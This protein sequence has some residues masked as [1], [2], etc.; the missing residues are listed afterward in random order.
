MR[1]LYCIKYSNNLKPYYGYIKP[2]NAVRDNTTYSLTYLPPS[3]I[4]GVQK[5][6]GIEGNIVRHRLLFDTNGQQKDFNKAIT[7]EKENKNGSTVH[8][9]YCLVNPQIL[10]GFD[11]KEDAEYCLNQPIHLGQMQYLIY[12]DKKY[13]IVEMNDEEFNNLK[14]VETFLTNENDGLYVG[15]NRQ[16][17]NERMYIDIIRNNW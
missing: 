1:K 17:N 6:L 2:W 7:Y 3:F 16:K 11:N 9:R 14:G 4:D 8:D 10:F 12:P 5:N 13:G 15:N